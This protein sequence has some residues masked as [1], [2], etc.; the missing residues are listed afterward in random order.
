MSELDEL[1][2]QP[3]PDDVGIKNRDTGSALVTE[4]DRLLCN[5][6]GTAAVP[7]INGR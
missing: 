2:S 6:T 3:L 1:L 7:N 5:D 4:G